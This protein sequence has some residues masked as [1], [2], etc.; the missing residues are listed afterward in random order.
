MIILYVE[1]VVWTFDHATELIH[2]RHSLDRAPVVAAVLRTAPRDQYADVVGRIADEAEAICSSLLSEW[3]HGWYTDGIPMFR[4]PDWEDAVIDL[5][6]AL[7]AAGRTDRALD[8]VRSIKHSWKAGTAV[9]AVVAAVAQAGDLDKAEEAVRFI[10]QADAR[11]DAVT[12]VALATAEAATRPLSG[13]TR[14][15]R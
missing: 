8:I 11:W 14:R 13:C 3:D 15:V 10:Y 7:A 5:A 1:F 2:R 4:I 12:D 6:T 9:A